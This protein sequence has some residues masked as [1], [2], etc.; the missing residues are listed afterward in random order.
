[1]SRALEEKEIRQAAQLKMARRLQESTLI[2]KFK[3]SAQRR[4]QRWVFTEN[5]HN[6]VAY[7]FIVSM[8][9]TRCVWRS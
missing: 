6:I 2:A 8:G 7:F 1:M 5:L 4:F 9:V 3:V